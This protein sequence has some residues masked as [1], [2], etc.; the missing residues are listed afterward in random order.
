MQI[1]VSMLRSFN[2]TIDAEIAQSKVTQRLSRQT[3]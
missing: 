1:L 2:S 3:P